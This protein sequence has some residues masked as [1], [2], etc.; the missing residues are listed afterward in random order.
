M[1]FIHPDFRAVAEI[2]FRLLK[3]CV[4]IYCSVLVNS[5]SL[6][7]REHTLLFDGPLTWR[8]SRDRMIPLHVV[9]LDSILLLLQKQDDS[10]LVLRCESTLI[11]AGKEDTKTTHSPIIKLSNL[12]IRSVATGE[13]SYKSVTAIVR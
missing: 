6:N 5:Q 2:S 9:L 4:L 10:R 7:V 3:L 11:T 13:K 1:I 12:I 8:I